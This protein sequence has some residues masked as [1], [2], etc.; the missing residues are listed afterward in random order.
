[1]PD[2][3]TV[4]VTPEET[5]EP[6]ATEVTEATESVEST[7]TPSA[8]DELRDRNKKLEGLVY[9]P[10][11]AEFLRWKAQGAQPTAK[12]APSREERD[13]MLA[14]LDQMDKGQYARF[15]SDAV[16]DRVREEL[17][18]PLM[19]SIVAEKVQQDIAETSAKYGDFWQ[20]KDRMVQ[21]AN[22][23]PNLRAEQVYFLAKGGAPVAPVTPPP[24][25][26][27]KP[28]GEVPGGA[29]ATAKPLEQPKFEEAFDVA[30]KKAGL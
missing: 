26:P 6:E 5:K 13:E 29:R 10:E 24:A 27:R 20:H 7:P 17:F 19:Q 30:F 14:R 23:N 1:M 21:I 16:V 2:E 8:L 11:Y 28:S 4:V 18:S 12:P 3:T 25:K 15:V 22:A 9:S